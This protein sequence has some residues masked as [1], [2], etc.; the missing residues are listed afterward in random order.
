MPTGPAYCYRAQC[1]R[2]IDGDTFVADVD[3]GFRVT[4]AV[5]VRLR[6]VNSP[7]HNKPGGQDATDF[8][9]ALL[10]GTQ[11]LLESYKDQQS[12]TRWVCDVW[13]PTGQSL[14]DAIV[15]AGHGTPFDPAHDHWTL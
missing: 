6:G 5:T 9:N 13:L 1:R 4:C 2:V 15:A 12:F 11:L 8:L 7:E 3:L 14:A 10:T